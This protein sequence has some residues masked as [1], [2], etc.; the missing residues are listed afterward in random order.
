VVL[1]CV[2][3][4]GVSLP[5]ALLLL[6][7]LLPRLSGIGGVRVL[8]DCWL[9]GSEPS[10]RSSTNCIRNVGRTDDFFIFFLIFWKE[11]LLAVLFI[12]NRKWCSQNSPL[13][14]CY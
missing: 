3:E 2:Y 4:F 9:V 1:F 8:G 5:H 12:G 14:T 10:L 11:R 7:L 6:Q 13:G